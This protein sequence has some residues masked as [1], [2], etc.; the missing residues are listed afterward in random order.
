M[1]SILVQ[2]LYIILFLLFT[3]N[4]VTYANL[5]ISSFHLKLDQ[6]FALNMATYANLIIPCFYLY[7]LGQ[8]FVPNLWAA[9]CT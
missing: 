4:M 7:N 8:T 5:S 1:N 6:L 9:I 3:S 2:S